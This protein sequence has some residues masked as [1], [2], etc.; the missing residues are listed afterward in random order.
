MKLENQV[1]N[2]ELSKKLKKLGVKQESLFYWTPE[3]TE[4]SYLI[5]RGKEKPYFADISAFTVAELGEMLPKQLRLKIKKGQCKQGCDIHNEWIIA[6]LDISKTN[7]DEWLVFYTWGIGTEN[8]DAYSNHWIGEIDQ[9]EAN[10]RA[11]MFIYLIENK[12]LK[13]KN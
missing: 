2:L 5:Y 8:E 13:A 6:Q 9:N 1:C 3:E 11:K 4:G 7:C 10:A 12:L